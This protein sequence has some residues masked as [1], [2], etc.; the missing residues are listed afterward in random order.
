MVARE[1]EEAL[2]RSCLAAALEGAQSV[3]VMGCR[4]EGGWRRERGKVLWIDR[5]CSLGALSV[6]SASALVV[7]PRGVSSN[8]EFSAIVSPMSIPT[9]KP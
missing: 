7:G 8:S 3:W 6:V 1:G 5:T 9:L 2:A 4:S